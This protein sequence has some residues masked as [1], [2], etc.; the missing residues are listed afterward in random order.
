MDV[1]NPPDFEVALEKNLV[2][3]MGGLE[4]AEKR[5]TKEVGRLGQLR[6]LAAAGATNP[7]PARQVMGP[8]S[9]SAVE[10]A[11][12]ALAKE[13]NSTKGKMSKEVLDE[14]QQA[15]SHWDKQL[16][17][18]PTA[19][20]L[21]KMSVE[22]ALHARQMIDR[23]VTFRESNKTLTDGFNKASELL[24]TK[25]ND[26]IRKESPRTAELT[27]EMAKVVPFAKA[28][29]RRNLQAGNNYKVGL[30]DLS[31]LASGGALG[32]AASNPSIAVPALAMSALAGRKLTSTPGGAAM[33]YDAGRSLADA[34]ATRNTLAQLARS[35]YHKGKR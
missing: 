19:D 1:P 34:S 17:F 29:G 30:L 12:D 18:R 26:V 28:L 5:A 16:G 31:S 10:A 11:G 22:D 27:D 25:L 3:Y 14:A 15:L 24:R 9:G 32:M 2:P 6:D 23:E 7:V 35:T 20:N 33:M 4:G 8:G 13:F 21:G